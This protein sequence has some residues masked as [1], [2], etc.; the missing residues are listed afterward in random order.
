MLGLRLEGAVS[1]VELD[2]VALSKLASELNVVCSGT[3]A[4]STVDALVERRTAARAERDFALSDRIRD[5]LAALHVSLEDTA[6]G[7]RWSVEG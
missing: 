4:A 1:A 3:D 6:D 7:T 2:A 5:E